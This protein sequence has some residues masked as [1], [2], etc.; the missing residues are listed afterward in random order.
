MPPCHNW[1]ARTE[2]PSAM[3]HHPPHWHASIAAH[4]HSRQEQIATKSSLRHVGGVT[5]FWRREFVWISKLRARFFVSY[6][7]ECAPISKNTSIQ[8]QLTERK[9]GAKV[10]SVEKAKS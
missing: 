1:A 8:F 10:S 3:P 7:P 6:F 9:Q 2:P 4:Y 5:S